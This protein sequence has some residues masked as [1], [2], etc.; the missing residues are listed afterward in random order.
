MLQEAHQLKQKGVD[1]VVGIVDTHGR[2]DTEK[3]LEGLEQTPPRKVNY[4][5]HELLDMDMDAVLVRL[6]ELVLIDEL[7]PVVI[8]RSDG[9]MLKNVWRWV[10][11]L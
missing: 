6:P 4:K 9:R 2:E 5:G 11:T 7:A 3:L 10:S 8:M 1:V